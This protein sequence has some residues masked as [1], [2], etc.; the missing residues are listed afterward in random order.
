MTGIRTKTTGEEVCYSLSDEAK[1]IMESSNKNFVKMLRLV[2]LGTNNWWAASAI[3]AIE[4]NNL[5]EKQK[6]TDPKIV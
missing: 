4:Y 5:I 2:E 3:L 1:K 6:K